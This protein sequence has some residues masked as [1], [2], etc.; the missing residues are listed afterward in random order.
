MTTPKKEIIPLV[1]E[2][3]V[4]RNVTNTFFLVSGN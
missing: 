4:S 1:N 3:E 2:N